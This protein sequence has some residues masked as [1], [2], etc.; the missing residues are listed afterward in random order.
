M[1]NSPTHKYSFGRNDIKI[2][3]VKKHETIEDLMKNHKGTI[4]LYSLPKRKEK[5]KVQLTNMLS[6][7]KLKR[8]SS[9]RISAEN[10][11]ITAFPEI[12]RHHVD[13]LFDACDTDK[14]EW[15]IFRE[16]ELFVGMA[17]MIIQDDI[18]FLLYLA[19]EGNQ[20]N[21]GY[22]A[23]ILRNLSQKYKG[24][25]IILLIE[26]LQEECDNMD[27]RIRR[28]EFYMRNGFYD[29]KYIQSTC[30]GTAIY[31]ILSTKTDFCIDRWKNFIAH[32][33]MESY[34]DSTYQI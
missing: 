30:E 33:P 14:C 23:E 29:T 8:E 6:I 19:V 26:S 16:N 17:Y 25:E 12:E 9:E 1:S 31:D 27:I 32:Y 11:Y 28:K 3:Y 5:V 21:K 13:E 20:R 24:L 15:L 10:L 2:A 18:A 4:I 7:S 22:G 34:M